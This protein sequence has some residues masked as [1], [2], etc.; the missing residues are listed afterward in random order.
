MI[1]NYLISLSL[2]PLVAALI[3]WLVWT[4]RGKNRYPGLIW[5]FVLGM[6]SIVIVLMFQIIAQRFGLDDFKN[7]RRIIFYS[8]FVMGFGSELG[9][10]L[11]LRYHIFPRDS[12]NGPLDSIVYSIML[13]MGFAFIGNVLYLILPYYTE[14]DFRYAISVVPANL[15]FAVILGFFIGIAKSR[16]NKFVDSMT[17][18]FGASFFHA[19]YNFCFIT[20]DFRLLIFLSIGAFVVVILLYYK[21]FELN[22]E[23]K[24]IN[25][26]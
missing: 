5:A 17:G 11:L 19:L 9:K 10:Y 15:F 22:E 7:I 13:S 24:R 12:F 23:F 18:L 21:A 1:I 4:K 20:E 2:G 14:V 16:E 25:K 8:F 3:V 6:L 26:E